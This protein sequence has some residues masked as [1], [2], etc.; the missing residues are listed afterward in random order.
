MKKVDF[1]VVGSGGG[2][3]TISWLL[4][5]AGFRVVLLEQGNDFLQQA[6]AELRRAHTSDGDAGFNPQLHDEY[7]FRIERPDPK[8]RLRGAYNTFRKNDRSPSRP[9][10]GK[11]GGFTASVLGGGSVLW[12]TWSF[13]ALPIDFFLATHFR[14]LKQDTLLQEWGYAISDWP[15]NYAEFEPYY[16]LTEALFGTCG[17]RE[18]LNRAVTR[19]VWFREFKERL[20]TFGRTGNWEPSFRFQGPPY[21]VT[22]VG[23]MFHESMKKF[24]LNPVMLANSLISPGERRYQTRYAIGRALRASESIWP[25][26][27]VPTFWR[28]SEDDLWSERTRDACNM[29]GYCG[30]FAC[31]GRSGAKSG[32]RVTTI[33]ELADLPNAEILTDSLVYEVMYNSRTRRTIGVRYLDISDPDNPRQ[34]TLYAHNVVVSCGA[35]QSAKLLLMSGPPGGLGNR[36]DQVGRNACFHLFGMGAKGILRDEFQGKVHSEYGHTGNV[37]AFDYYFVED[38]RSVSDQKGMW[39]KAGTLASAAKK[40]PLENANN[41]V[42]KAGQLPE[43]ITGINLLRGVEPY[44]RLVEV[45]VTG[46]DLPMPS[47][48]VDLD[49]NFVD[50]YGFPVARITRDFG[51]HEQWMAELLKPRFDAMFQPY[52]DAK[53]LQT[54]SYQFTSGIVDLIGDHQ[55][56]TCRMGDDPANSVVDR[57]CRVHDVPNLFVVDSSFMPTGLG[58][59]PM[60]TVVANAL[61]VGTWI[62]EQ[63]R[64]SGS[65]LSC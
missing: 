36:F 14:E 23:Y 27:Q 59:N 12:G 42:T 16:N 60:K 8:R 28:A 51:K 65:E 58:V 11:M 20:P 13:R 34:E 55:F 24:G 1:V 6:E 46:D 49:P 56:G 21:P 41:L 25:N 32:T 52:L 17:D 47:N 44:A 4:A 3:G 9:L 30:E 29:C 18:E 50:E 54:G 22:P 40:N 5:K 43:N 48:R 61:R 37:T 26:G 10:G 45:R 19:T 15:I 53:V 63:S 57:Y 31:W 38:T 33:R 64:S 39:C 62:V 35:V 7:R 2:G